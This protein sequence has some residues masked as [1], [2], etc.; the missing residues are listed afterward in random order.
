MHGVCLEVLLGGLPLKTGDPSR[1]E[2]KENANVW[3]RGGSGLMG[4]QIT[5]TKRLLCNIH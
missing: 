3:G 4:L 2:L 5:E 1:I